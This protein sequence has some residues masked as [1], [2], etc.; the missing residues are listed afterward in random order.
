MRNSLSSESREN[1]DGNSLEKSGEKSM[2]NNTILKI[3]KFN[4][5]LFELQSFSEKQKIDSSDI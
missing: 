2:M 1:C 3:L 5:E 4:L